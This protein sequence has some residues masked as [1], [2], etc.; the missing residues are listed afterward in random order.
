MLFPSFREFTGETST[1]FESALGLFWY[2]WGLACISKCVGYVI[3]SVS[4]EDHALDHCVSDRLSLFFK[5]EIR[6]LIRF[7]FSSKKCVVK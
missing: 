6:E 1:L 4:N 7:V 2:G 5:V 3:M